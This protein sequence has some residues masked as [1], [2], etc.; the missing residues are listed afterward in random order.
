MT[1][2]IESAS[3]PARS[4]AQETDWS[5]VDADV[6]PNIVGGIK[7]VSKYLPL[8]WRQRFET[9]SLPSSRFDSPVGTVRRDA[10]GPNREPAAST[11]GLIRDDL[12][13]QH[14]VLSAIL[15]SLEAARA[16]YLPSGVDASMLMGAFNE[17]LAS[18]WLDADPRLRLA[19][20]VAAAA[21][22]RAAAEIRKWADD[23][24]V[25]CVYL[26]LVNILMGEEHYHPIYAAAQDAGL[27]I[28][29]H[30]ANGEGQFQGGPALA[31][32]N[33]TSYAQRHVMLPQLAQSSVISLIFEGAL[34]RFTDLKFVF[35]EYGTS[36]VPHVLWRMDKDWR[37]L[38]PSLPW[39]RK[40]PIDTSSSGYGSPPS[41]WK[42]RQRLDSSNNC[43]K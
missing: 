2:T 32:G 28:M 10:A 20:V 21:P 24:R 26:P 6:H 7:T 30:P 31:G 36:W 13:D 37:G 1:S 17:Y 5:C 38:R 43:L 29:V 14:E 3:S 12:L 33:P 41:Q 9:V 15:I 18:E 34:E 42:S 8:S 22:Y 23:P 27:P 39:I 16:A 11:P 25:A 4:S 40:S 19:I 35:T